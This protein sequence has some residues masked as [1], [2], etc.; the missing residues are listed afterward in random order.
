MILERVVMFKRELGYTWRD[1][2]HVNDLVTLLNLE[3]IKASGTLGTSETDVPLPGRPSSAVPHEQ[4]GGM[5]KPRV[6]GMA[7]PIRAARYLKGAPVCE[8]VTPTPSMKRRVF[9]RRGVSCTWVAV[10]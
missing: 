1:E 5:G 2:R 8:W 6:G 4:G 7:R 3:L 9:R 10:C